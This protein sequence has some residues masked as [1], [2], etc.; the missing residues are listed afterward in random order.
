MKTLFL[1]L[2][3]T[4]SALAQGTISLALEGTPPPGGYTAGAQVKID[5]V[6]TGNPTATGAQWNL[7][8][9]TNA[10]P[11][12]SAGAAAVASNKNLACVAMTSPSR[13]LLVGLANITPI[14]DGVIAIATITMPSNSPSFTLSGVL[15]A[16]SDGNS[17]AVTVGN[18]TISLSP[19]SPCDVDGDG[20]VSSSDTSAVV[21]VAVTGTSSP[22]TDLNSDSATN[23]LDAQIASTAASGGTCNAH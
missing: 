9:P 7:S 17:V 4:I 15:E 19:H 5:I 1:S 11:S 22:A 12:F 21:S 13:C 23:I 8:F 16:D 20:S 18:P 6:K 10:V 14:P 2:L 3:F